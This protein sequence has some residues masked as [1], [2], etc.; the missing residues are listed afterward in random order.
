MSAIP[1]VMKDLLVYDY[2]S[3]AV[4]PYACIFLGGREDGRV[5]VWC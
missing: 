1:K 2:S 5:V 3:G 4:E